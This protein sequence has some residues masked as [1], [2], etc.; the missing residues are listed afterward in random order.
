MSLEKTITSMF[1]VPT[2]GLDKTLLNQYNYLNSYSDL[3][4]KE[5]DYD[6]HVVYILFKPNSKILF[7]DF[8]NNLYKYNNSILEDFNLDNDFV[9]VVFQLN[10]EFNIDY[11][12]IKISKYSKTSKKFQNLFPE[13]VLKQN[14]K[15]VRKSLQTLVFNKDKSLVDY[16]EK[17]IGSEFT[18]DMEVWYS[19]DP[20]KEILDFEQI[21]K[22]LN[23]GKPENNLK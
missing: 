2:L 18:E 22:T 11:E 9:V 4:D 7:K 6:P 5:I 8:L 19:F 15:G 13:T 20:E 3:K 1:L 17:K 10:E 21:L 12:L 16:W 14:S 23:N